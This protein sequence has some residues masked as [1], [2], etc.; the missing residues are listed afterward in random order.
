MDLSNPSVLYKIVGLSAAPGL[1]GTCLI[2]SRANEF[3]V[4]WDKVFCLGR[5]HIPGK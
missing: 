5:M 2:R 3:G 1:P 4:G